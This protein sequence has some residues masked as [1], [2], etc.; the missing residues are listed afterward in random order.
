MEGRR[1]KKTGR[2]SVETSDKKLMKA[3]GKP[4]KNLLVKQ[5]NG[6]SGR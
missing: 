4:G 2:N 6:K 3:S 5:T 1:T